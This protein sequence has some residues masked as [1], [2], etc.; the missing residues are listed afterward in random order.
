VP[1]RQKTVESVNVD[2]R[3]IAF[4]W[5]EIESSNVAWIGWPVTGEPLMIVQYHSGAYYG[6]IGVPRQKAV[7]AANA[8]S[9]GSYINRNIRGKYRPVRLEIE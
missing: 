5:H 8:V 9:T 4:N 2:G 7:A 6:Y 3:E 1:V